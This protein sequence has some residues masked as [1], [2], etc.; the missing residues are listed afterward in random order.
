MNAK[1]TNTNIYDDIAVAMT[2]LLNDGSQTAW[3]LEAGATFTENTDG[4][5]HLQGTVK[6]FGDYTT[7][8]RMALDLTLSGKSYSPDASGPYN[9]TGVSTDGWYYYTSLS[10]SFTGLDALAGWQIGFGYSH[11]PFPS[12]CWCEPTF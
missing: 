5:A 11:A 6:Q 7:T 9:Q 10:G 8:R 4:T 12:G 2:D 1:S 3:L